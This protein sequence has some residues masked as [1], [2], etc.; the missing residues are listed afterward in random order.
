[1]TPNR[2]IC[3]IL[4]LVVPL[5]ALADQDSN[6]DDPVLNFEH[7]WRTLDRTYAQFGAKYVDWDALYRVYRPRITPE[8][9]ESELWDIMLTMMGHL[10]DS[11]VC[12]SDETR[13]ICVG[14]VDEIARDDF[15]LDLVISK[16]LCGDTS[17]ALGGSFTYGWLAD[18]IGYL[19]IGLSLSPK[20]ANIVGINFQ[21]MC[22]TA[23]FS[24]CCD[25]DNH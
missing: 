1:M 23:P 9:T 12:L 7:L 11:H 13:R 5:A 2:V 24:R 20:L 10:N 14:I 17:T 3:M 6:P 4:A 15:S 19:H 25:Y 18:G 22:Q 16:H 21:K 8:T